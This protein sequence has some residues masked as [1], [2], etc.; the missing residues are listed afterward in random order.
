MNKVMEPNKE[1]RR[2][3][4]DKWVYIA[5][6]FAIGGWI[7]FIFALV[8]SHYAA[9]E[10]DYG[11]L[12]YYNIEVRKNWL[13]PLTDYLYM[14]L[15]LSAASSFFYLFIQKYRRRRKTDNRHFNLWLLLVIAIAWVVYIYIQTSSMNY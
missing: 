1:N 8:L 10:K 14:V 13:Q 11:M 6:A 12:R 5:R 15:W 9:P 3:E 2:K 7:F 4:P